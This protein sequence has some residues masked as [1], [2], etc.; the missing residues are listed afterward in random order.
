[1]RDGALDSSSPANGLF[2]VITNPWDQ[3]PAR[4]AERQGKDG[5]FQLSIIEQNDSMPKLPTAVVTP[6]TFGRVKLRRRRYQEAPPSPPPSANK[7]MLPGS[8]TTGV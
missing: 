8:G 7:S 2:Q 1:M 6:Q 3:C 4:A 5:D